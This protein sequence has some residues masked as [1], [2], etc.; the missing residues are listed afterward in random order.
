M[1][2]VHDRA[3]KNVTRIVNPVKKNI[4]QKTPPIV[5]ASTAKTNENLKVYRNVRVLIKCL[6]QILGLLGI[7]YS[8]DFRCINWF[9]YTT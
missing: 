2:S 9:C 6:I 3:K 7:P 4:S 8:R 5:E 1:K